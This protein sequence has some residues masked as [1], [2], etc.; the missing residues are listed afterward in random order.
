[1]DDN[2]WVNPLVITL[3]SQ[4]LANFGIFVVL[5]HPTGSPLCRFRRKA[6]EESRDNTGRHTS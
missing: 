6:G 1:M 3:T 2:Q 5:L 4:Y